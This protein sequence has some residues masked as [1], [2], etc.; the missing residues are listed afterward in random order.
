MILWRQSHK[1]VVRKERNLEVDGRTVLPRSLAA[2]EWKELLDTDAFAMGSDPLFMPG[3]RVCC[4]PL[5]FEIRY[6]VSGVAMFRCSFA[7][8]T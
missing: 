4:E 7:I 5:P 8:V 2:I 3:H 1:K 6:D